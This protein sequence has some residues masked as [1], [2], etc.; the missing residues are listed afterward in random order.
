MLAVGLFSTLLSIRTDIEAFSITV[1]GF[2]MSAY[3]L[4]LLLGA[5]FAVKLVIRV[6]HIRAFGIYASVMSTA[7]IIH[8]MFIDP[9]TWAIIR[10][11]CGFCMAGLILITEAWLNERATNKVRG[12]LLAVYM[13][14]G[15]G[16]SGLGQFILPLADPAGFKLFGLIS[17]IFSFALVP[18]LLTKAPSP[19]AATRERISP[20]ELYRISP[21]AAVGTFLAGMLNSSFYSMGPLFTRQIGLSLS[22]T[23]AFMA[24]VILGGLLL[25]MPIGKISDRFDRR[26]V[27]IGNALATSL[28]CA[29]VLF[30]IATLDP[31]N[32][33]EGNAGWPLYLAGI[34]Y[35]SLA[36]TMYSLCAAQANDLTPP[37]KL[38]Q[39]AGGLLLAFG[40]G[41]IF[42]PLVGGLFMQLAGAKSLFVYFL[43]LS[44][45]IAGHTLLRL[46]ARKSG[47]QKRA[48][49]PKPGSMYA[50][51]TLFNSATKSKI[52]E[53]IEPLQTHTENTD[54]NGQ[55][56]DPTRH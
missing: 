17:I 37:D 8:I 14:T 19:R 47:S 54:P 24:C 7:A 26:K 28:A 53:K 18:V 39:T 55:A 46:R 16:F 15:Y 31:A 44:L 29:A 3:F 2:V 40:T 6:G 51:Q 22:S 36:F 4:G 1:T 30:A 21:V 5:L 34:V 45:G 48:F 9:L 23:S 50:D 52:N 12:Q 11:I 41:A 49:V 56:E 20:L 42:G 25:Q 27:L 35:G 32:T 13:A 43:L 33:N 38:I 10:A